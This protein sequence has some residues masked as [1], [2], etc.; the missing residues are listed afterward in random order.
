MAQEVADAI[1]PYLDA[2]NIDLKGDAKFYKEVCGG[3]N[4]NRVKENI[5]LFHKKGVHVEVTNLIVPGYND[6]EPQ[7][8]EVSEFVA[9]LSSE[10]PLHFS[11]FF[12]CWKLDYIPQTPEATIARA[13]E[14]AEKAGLKY[15]YT[16]NIQ[17]GE[18]TTNCK[19]CGTTL[20]ARHN[21]STEVVG[22]DGK[23]CKKCGTENNIIV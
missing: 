17:S 10:I 21:Y 5:A 2:I 9:S 14:I 7:I 15:V 16:G 22:L 23:K 11:A 19:K 4:L 18:N 13:K 8:R 6:R 20:I 3:V 12:P 1:S